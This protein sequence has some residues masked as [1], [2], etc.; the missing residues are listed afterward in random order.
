MRGFF[1]SIIA[2]IF[3]FVFV[4]AFVLF[5]IL[6]TILTADFYKGNFP[7]KVREAVVTMALDFANS[8][9]ELKN[10]SYSQEKLKTDI[11]AILKP[12]YFSNLIAQI[13]DQLQNGYIDDNENREIV[14]D[15]TALKKSSVGTSDVV[16][17]QFMKRIPDKFTFDIPLQK[18]PVFGNNIFSAE[19]A[20]KVFMML[21]AVL[22]FLIL[23]VSLIIFRPWH[24]IVKWIGGMFITVS[25]SSGLMFLLIYY[26]PRL[27]AERGLIN[28][29]NVDPQTVAKYL[30]IF[31]SIFY[32]VLRDALIYAGIVFA[33]GL[34]LVIF[35]FFGKKNALKKHYKT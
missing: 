33:F 1:A 3:E 16:I 5:V 8:Q 32:A 23:L 10:S 35:A 26:T 18:D 28:Y 7:I 20:W 29:Q 9:P 27:L 15:L 21:S 2:V 34:G 4:S 19:F 30:D 6:N 24:R 22:G 25:I 14:L 13:T 12:E 17:D 31:M 11:E